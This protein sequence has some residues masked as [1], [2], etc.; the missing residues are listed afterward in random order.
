MGQVSGG[1][2]G[3]GSNS[4]GWNEALAGKVLESVRPCKAK[5]HG[6]AG[7]ALGCSYCRDPTSIERNSYASSTHSLK[8]CLSA[9]TVRNVCTVPSTPCSSPLHWA[10]CAWALIFTMSLKGGLFSTC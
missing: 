9:H 8:C 1:G 4:R 7:P 6:L 3:R 2:G 10:L 5:G